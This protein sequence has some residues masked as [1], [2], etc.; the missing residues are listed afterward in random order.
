MARGVLIAF[1][2][3]DGTGKSS[4]VAQL[5]DFLRQ[6]GCPVV[7]TR[8]P[9]QGIH[10]RRIRQMYTARHHF[11]PEEELELFILD[12]RDHVKEV[13]EPGLTQGNIVLTDR[14]YYSTAAYQGAAGIDPEGILIQNRF[15]PVPDLVLLLELPPD[16][17][18]ERIRQYRGDQLNDFE[19]VDQ[20]HKVSALFSRFT[21]RCI[22]RI[23]AD[24]SLETVQQE[25]RRVTSTLLEQ[26]GFSCSG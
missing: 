5:A 17:A 19:H 4:Q 22:M 7:E 8:E 21:D 26:R 10:G 1:E 23:D 20:L 3:I 15:A 6:R 14:Y 18:I 12:R 25:I 16:K 11:S 9:T 24:R 13:I 2:G